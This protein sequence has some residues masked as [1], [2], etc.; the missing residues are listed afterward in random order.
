MR[1]LGGVEEPA[2]LHTVSHTQRLH[3]KINI[4]DSALSIC[5][6]CIL[7]QGANRFMICGSNVVLGKLEMLLR[8]E[9]VKK[10]R[11]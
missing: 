6:C 5:N 8:K 10:G 9:V 4:N 2:L 1:R 3:M 7:Y 11:Y